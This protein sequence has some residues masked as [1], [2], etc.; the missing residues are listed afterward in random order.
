MK[1]ANPNPDPVEQGFYPEFNKCPIINTF[2]S[3]KPSDWV[4]NRDYRAISL[5][6]ACVNSTTA[7]CKVAQ[8]TYDFKKGDIISGTPT[9][10]D[11]YDKLYHGIQTKGV[12][13]PYGSAWGAFAGQYGSL[14]E[15][16]PISPV[17]KTAPTPTDQIPTDQTVVHNQLNQQ[18]QKNH[19]LI[20]AIVFALI[21]GSIFWYKKNK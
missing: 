13:V 10:I 17:I 12:Y 15:L 3:V 4:F 2:A 1:I 9:C 5:P 18:K 20:L 8:T 7:P 21:I 16:Y 19:N 14:T 11:G 6:P